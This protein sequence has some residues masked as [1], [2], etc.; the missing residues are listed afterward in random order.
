[1]KV[2]G[3]TKEQLFKELKTLQ[4]R[5]AKLE[6]METERKLAEEA[7][8]ESEEKFRG[9]SEK[10]LVGVYLIQDEVFK[11][12]NPT[13]AEIF[14]YTAKELIDKKGPKDLVLPEDWPIVKENLRKRIS[15]GIVPPVRDFKA[16]TK[17]KKIIYIEVHGS[18]TV[19]HGRPAVVGTLS[20]ITERKRAEEALQE[21]EERYRRLH[22]SITDGAFV[23]DREFRYVVVNDASLKLVG[24]PR[25]KL[26]GN[27]ITDV[28]KGIESTDFFKVYK[29]VMKSRK[30]ETNA[31][32]FQHPDGRKGWNEVHDYPH[33]E[34]IL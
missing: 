24:M 29:K 6:R 23:L 10:S 9:L 17:N 18:G 3:K 13:L 26:I 25:K 22:E 20:D 16:I 12:V 1:M 31:S 8:R 28:F 34:G 7:L 15:G 11:Y 30:P 32:E 4:G 2:R 5:L 33:Q 14:G 19:Y 21:S 27:K